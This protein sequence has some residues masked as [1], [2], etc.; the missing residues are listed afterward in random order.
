M[1]ETGEALQAIRRIA[2][3]GQITDTAVIERLGG[4]SNRVYRVRAEGVDVVLR[5]PGEGSEAYIDRAAEAVNAR[6]ATAAGISP[7]VLHFGADGV[8]L[9][10]YVPQSVTMSAAGFVGR[11]GAVERAGRV[12]RQLHDRTAPFA[13]RFDLFE[14]IDGY[15]AHLG[16]LGVE[17]PEGYADLV[18]EAG[19]IRARLDASPAALAPC[20][21]DPLCEN[22]LDTGDRMWIVDW[23]YAGNNDPAWDLGDLSV[24]GEFTDAMDER[25][26]GA[27]YGRPPS[28]AEHG[29]MVVHKALSDTLWTLWGLI[30]H[31]NG[32]PAD[33]FLAYAMV[34]LDRC[35]ALMGTEAFARHLAAVA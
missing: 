8:M 21:C 29:R 12:L 31:A 14:M 1:T 27:Y 3:Y 23:E 2:G 7:Q 16:K 25:L 17:M 6:A 32:N 26:L 35:R 22:F 4:L 15:L 20:H 34:R 9:T 24:E 5:L 18:A 13:A 11:E 28:A 30:Q 19:R 10:E 33:D